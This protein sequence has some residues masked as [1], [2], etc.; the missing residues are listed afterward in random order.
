[1]EDLQLVCVQ[2]SHLFRPSCLR[3]LP[4][5]GLAARDDRLEEQTVMLLDERHEMNVVVDG[6]DLDA[7]PGITV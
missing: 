3:H 4:H 2:L 6:D 1:V 5:L 7:L